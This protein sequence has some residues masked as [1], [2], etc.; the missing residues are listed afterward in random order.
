[1]G[2]LARNGTKVSVIFSLLPIYIFGNLHCAGMCGPLVMLLAKHPYRWAYFL[3]RLF[4]YTLVGLISAEMGLFLFSFLARYHVGASI[5]LLFGLVIVL[6]GFSLLVKRRLPGSAWLGRRGALLSV[7]L[8]HL[9]STDS[10]YAVFLF[11]ACTL[12]LPCGQTLIVFSVI[13]LKGSPLSGILNGFLFALLTSPA[14]IA[15]MHASQLFCKLQK[16][17]HLWMG[18]AALCVGGLAILRGLADL[19]W[20][21]HL[22]LNPPIPRIYHI[23][24]Y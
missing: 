4:S 21:N 20:I 3:G 18:S 12:L 9:L 23:V 14:L 5:S 17:Y 8:A 11:G 22:V 24:L 15:A 1:M 6:I 2:L 16:G 7:K 13:A 19:D 10:F